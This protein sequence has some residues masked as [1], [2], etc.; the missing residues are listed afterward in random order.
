MKIWR[1]TS[2]TGQFLMG[3]F[4]IWRK[5]FLC[6]KLRLKRQQRPLRKWKLRIQVSNQSI[7][8]HSRCLYPWYSTVGWENG[9]DNSIL[10]GH[11]E[12]LQPVQ[13]E[14]RRQREQLTWGITTLP[15]SVLIFEKKHC[16]HCKHIRKRLEEE[17]DRVKGKWG[18]SNG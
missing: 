5:R 1:R 17:I 8:G 6:T 3:L 16:S 2:S 10:R 18:M 7:A 9:Y 14:G 13:K 11:T 4:L 12:S 15:K